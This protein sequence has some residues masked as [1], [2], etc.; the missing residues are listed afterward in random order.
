MRNKKKLGDYKA[1]EFVGGQIT[2]RIE[3]DIEKGDV[4]CR[5]VKTIPPKAISGGKIDKEFLQELQCKTEVDANRLTQEGDVVLKLSTPYD[6]AYITKDD[7]NL[8]IP[9]FCLIIRIKDTTKLNPRFLTAFINSNVYSMQVKEMVSGGMVPMLTMG[10]IKE[11]LIKDFT[12][13]E[14]EMIATFYENVC[15]REDRF[16]KIIEIEKE[17]I[18][19]VLGGGENEQ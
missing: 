8:L 9:S 2:K 17:K 4:V 7:V 6:A 19:A 13:E 14:Q 1:I 16:K 12:I 3:S 5:T 18:T 15:R 10:K 11:V